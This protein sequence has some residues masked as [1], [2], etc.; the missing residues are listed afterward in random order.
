MPTE[1]TTKW[2]VTWGRTGKLLSNTQGGK[3]IQKSAGAAIGAVTNGLSGMPGRAL[4]QGEAVVRQFTE[5]HNRDAKSLAPVDTGALLSKFDTEYEKTP[6]SFIG[7]SVNRSEYAAFQEFGFHHWVNGRFVRPQP[8][9]FPA[10]AKRRQAFI[11]AIK[12]LFG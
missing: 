5:D 9:M 12:G 7:R 4:D 2:T 1:F 8:F 10:F 6:S 3:Q 11:N